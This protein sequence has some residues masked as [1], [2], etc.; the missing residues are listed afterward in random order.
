MCP[1]TVEDQSSG[2][3]LTLGAELA[4]SERETSSTS[5]P[6]SLR[7]TVAIA[8]APNVLT[9]VNSGTRFV[10]VLTIQSAGLDASDDHHVASAPVLPDHG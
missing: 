5:G 8:V 6:Q 9:G 4:D 7:K 1:Q 10:V 3:R 2:P